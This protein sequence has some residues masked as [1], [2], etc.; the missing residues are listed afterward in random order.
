[1]P[2][3]EKPEEGSLA[4]KVSMYSIVIPPIGE[5]D[6]LELIDCV[7]VSHPCFESTLSLDR[8]VET[9]GSEDGEGI[10]SWGRRYAE[11]SP[12]PLPVAPSCPVFVLSPPL[13]LTENT[14]INPGPGLEE[15]PIASFIGSLS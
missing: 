15:N 12:S 2:G 11:S 13:T 3:E 4:A 8:T 1:M 9:V 10:I 7:S 6:Q 14:Y 5:Y